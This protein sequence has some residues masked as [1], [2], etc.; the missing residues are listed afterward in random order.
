MLPQTADMLNARPE[1]IGNLRNLIEQTGAEVV[2][3]DPWRL[4]LG[5]DENSAEDVVRGLRALSGLRESRPDLTIVIVHHVRK[6]RFIRLG[7]PTRRSPPLD[8]V[9]EWSLRPRVPRGRVLGL[10]RQRRDE[11]GEEWIAFG[12]IARNTEP[13]TILLED[14]EDTL[15]FEVRRGEAVLEAILTPKEREIWK[16][17]M[18]LKRVFGFNELITHAGITNRKAASSMLRKA[19]KGAITLAK[20]RLWADRFLAAASTFNFKS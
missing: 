11:A 10:E 1:G 13:R 7:R 20:D 8:R 4:W 14:D 2:I 5:G 17:A 12:G 16:A 15:R 18:K 19:E 3:V 9:R 6:D